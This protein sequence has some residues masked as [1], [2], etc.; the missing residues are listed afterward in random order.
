MGFYPYFRAVRLSKLCGNSDDYCIVDWVRPLTRDKYLR[1]SI[2]PYIW[3]VWLIIKSVLYGTCYA[4]GAS[5]QPH[6]QCPLRPYGIQTK[7]LGVL[8][9]CKQKSLSR[10]HCQM[11]VLKGS[12]R[13]DW[14]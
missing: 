8:C 3:L 14:N 12:V 11:V 9:Y 7:R 2:T 1:N 4:T 10:K 6:V 13:F 5:C